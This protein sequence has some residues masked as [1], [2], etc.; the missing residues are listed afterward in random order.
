MKF[1]WKTVITTSFRKKAEVTL[2]SLNVLDNVSVVV[3]GKKYTAQ[4]L[5]GN[6][7]KVVF[8]DIQRAGTYD[9]DVFENDN[10]IGKIEFT[11]RKESAHENDL[12]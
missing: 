4:K 11:V 3:G 1:V 8:P 10:L 7:H 2:F 6:R 12:F 5:D 9:A